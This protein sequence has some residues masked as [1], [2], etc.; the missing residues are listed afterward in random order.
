M[1]TCTYAG[2]GVLAAAGVSAQAFETDDAYNR[3]IMANEVFY[4]ADQ[5]RDY[6]LTEADGDA[7]VQY[8]ELD[9]NGDGTVSFEEF[10][11]GVALGRLPRTNFWLFGISG[12]SAGIAG[13]QTGRSRHAG[14][15]TGD[16]DAARPNRHPLKSQR[17]NIIH[18]G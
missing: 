10:T 5:T 18:E 1:K 11:A 13:F 7:W 9:A 8:A 16:P 2:V 4:K 3:R 12:G 15:E 6:K 17:A 14:L